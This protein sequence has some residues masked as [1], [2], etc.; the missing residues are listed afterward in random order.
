[1]LP[2]NQD[3]PTKNEY[4]QILQSP[5]TYFTDP[6][7]KSCIVETDPMG[8]PK[9]R[10]GGFAL[11]YKVA[12]SSNKWALRCFHKP[13]QE[14][15]PRY[16]VICKYIES[17]PSPILVN[18]DY[19]S[20]GLR[21]KGRV[22]PI[23]LME[24]IEG[25]TLGNYVYKNI[26]NPKTLRN[27]P[28]E[29]LGVSRELERLQIAH[30]D[31][32][33]QNIIILKNHM[34]LVDYD[35]MYIPDFKGYKS[36]ELGNINFQHPGRNQNHFGPTL[37]NFS[38]IVIYLG[39]RS[40]AQSP[41]LYQQYGLGGEGLLLKY[42]DFRN[43]YD[44]SILTEIERI[45]ELTAYVDKFKRICLADIS[46]IPRLMDFLEGQIIEIGQPSAQISQRQLAS[47]PIDAT[48]RGTILERE[49][50][51]VVIIGKVSEVKRGMTRKDLPYI[52]MNFG[53]WRQHCFTVV[54]WSD[55][56][57][58]FTQSGKNP[59]NYIDKWVSVSGVIS[60]YETTYGKRPQI[61]LD[62]P[63]DIAIITEQE[64]KDRLKGVGRVIIPD[65]PAVNYVTS[66]NHLD[67]PEKTTSSSTK[68]LEVFPSPI[69]P[70]SPT[71]SQALSKMNKIQQQTISV[72]SEHKFGDPPLGNSINNTEKLNKLYS[73]LNQKPKTPSNSIN[74]SSYTPSN[75]VMQKSTLSNSQRA[76]TVS[77]STK[78]T[79]KNIFRKILDWLVG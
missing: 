12:I 34:I 16:Q 2:L 5:R 58:L 76:Q 51:S 68:S 42:D 74:T 41:W 57:D 21:Y 8:F 31:L 73:T 15:G 33:N 32:S 11:T 37:D 29:F 7:V 69:Q 10:S 64:A 53:D 3:L 48:N 35:G 23:T 44:S 50:D 71:I 6:M 63:G 47:L 20:E 72:T 28:D 36:T 38:E 59:S 30:G 78:P 25:D 27:L 56:L 62:S 65:L 18:I 40:I 54:M 46:T 70:N 22:F 43:P 19:Q 67:N 17:H 26:N 1:M 13:S 61:I 14:R 66:K 75:P 77:T 79:K 55:T 24:W 39:L 45:P 60:V 49:D 9:V 4:Q 52:F